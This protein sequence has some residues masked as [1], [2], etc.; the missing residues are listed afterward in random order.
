VLGA[1]LQEAD[2]VEKVL[3]RSALD[4]LVARQR[5]LRYH[6]AFILDPWLIWG[7]V[8]RPEN[9]KIGHC[10]IYVDLVG[11]TW[12]QLARQGLVRLQSDDGA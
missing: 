8:D 2:V 7:G 12:P 4:Q 9:Y 1:F 11:Q 6:E 5:P 3:R 10:G